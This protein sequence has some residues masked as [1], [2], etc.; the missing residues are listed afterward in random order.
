MLLKNMLFI[1]FAMNLNKSLFEQECTSD[2]A[3]TFHDFAEQKREFYETRCF[4][5]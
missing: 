3:V 1:G 2:L 4:T 5:L